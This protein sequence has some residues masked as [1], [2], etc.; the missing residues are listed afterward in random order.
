MIEENRNMYKVDFAEHLLFILKKLDII[1]KALQ[2][3][4][5]EEK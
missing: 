2:D 4:N 3:T 1:E 5:K